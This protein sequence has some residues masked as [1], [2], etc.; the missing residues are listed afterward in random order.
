VVGLVGYTNAGKSTLLNALTGAETYA[1]DQLF[2]TLD[3]TLKRFPLS[4]ERH[5]VMADTVGF[6][7]DLPH[8]LVAAF[9]S[10]L[11]ETVEADLLLH[12]VDVTDPRMDET[13]DEVERVLSAIGAE[14]VPRL[15]IMNKIDGLEEGRPRIER[16]T[17][18]LISSLW[19]SARTGAGLALIA[20]AVRERLFP[21]K[22]RAEIRLGPFD[23]RI[24]AQLYQGGRVISERADTE[25]GW[26]LEI[27][28]SPESLDRW[29]VPPGAAD[30]FGEAGPMIPRGNREPKRARAWS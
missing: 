4:R 28:G 8:E 20:E 23:G 2:A 1:Q 22:A 18:G 6:V 5:V 12:V 30:D 21:K 24:R 16:G 25:G 29:G 26:I 13:L 7:R 3:P 15:R 17:D 19:V 9:R 10:T 11:K 27:E 14:T